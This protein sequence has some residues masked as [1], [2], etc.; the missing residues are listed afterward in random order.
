MIAI[1]VS[2]IRSTPCGDPAA[3]FSHIGSMRYGTGRPSP[4]V[5]AGTR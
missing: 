1:I 5:A 4:C 2:L 3:R